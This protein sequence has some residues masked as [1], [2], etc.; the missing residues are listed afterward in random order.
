MAFAPQQQLQSQS[1]LSSNTCLRAS[2]RDCLNWASLSAAAVTLT[3]FTGP[4]A[5]NAEVDY[6][7]IQDLLK[8]APQGQ[9]YAPANAPTPGARPKWLTEPTDDF[10][11]NERK[12]S[13][14]KRQQIQIKAE[15]Q[16]I[17]DQLQVEVNSE[18]AIAGDLDALRRLVRSNGGL[19]LGITKEDVVKQV[20]RKKAKKYWPTNVEIAYQD[21]IAEISYQTSPNNAQMGDK[22]YL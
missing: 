14:F 3:A 20:R 12:S 5:A 8:D 19:P 10:K 2:R 15:F 21:L 4:R 11:E 22:K 17:L 13:D 16:K 6:D 1:Q 9:E 18:D 7:R